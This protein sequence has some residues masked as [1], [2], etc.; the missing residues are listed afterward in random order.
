MYVYIYLQK[1]KKH[2]IR[3][4]RKMRLSERLQRKQNVELRKRA[5]SNRRNQSILT[6]W[7]FDETSSRS[8]YDIVMVS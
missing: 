1:Y 2:S 3:E 4:N 7:K 8:H 6:K 5:I